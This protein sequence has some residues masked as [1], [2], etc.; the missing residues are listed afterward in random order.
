M[1]LKHNEWIWQ[2]TFRINCF[3]CVPPK[4]AI[5]PLW[6]VLDVKVRGVLKT[7]SNSFPMNTITLWFNIEM[8]EKIASEVGN[9]K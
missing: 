8:N 6:V 5:F 2:I 1:C 4:N 7:E 3:S 9:P